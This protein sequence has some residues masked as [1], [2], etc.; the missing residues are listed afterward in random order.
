M[1][2]ALHTG[3]LLLGENN[4]SV[5]GGTGSAAVASLTWQSAVA[6]TGG[7]LSQGL[8]FLVIIYI[9]RRLSISEFGLISFA[10]AVSAYCLTLSNFG[11]PVFGSRAVARS[12][13]VP[14][15]LLGEIA[16]LRACLALTGMIVSVTVLWLAPEVSRLELLLI[17]IFGLSN[18]ALAGLFDWAFQGLHRQDVSAVLNIICQGGWLVLTVV[19][20]HL[21][22]GIMAVPTALSGAALI[23]GI[24]G[25]L[26]LR[27]TGQIR[28]GDN[29]Q[30]NVVRRSW[31]IL[32]LGA[33][34]GLGTLLVTVLIWSDAIVIR[35]L[36][37]QEAVGLY[38]A[39]NRAA[40][41]LAMLSSF[42]VQGAFPL[43]SRAGQGD[44]VHLNQYFQRCYEDMALVFVP[45]SIWAIFYAQSIILLVFRKPEYLA[46]TPV[47]RIF[48][49]TFLLAAL[50]NLFGIGVVVATHQDGEYQK[51]L[52]LAT[53]AFLPL[54]VGLSAWAGNLGASVAALVAQAV[55]L[56]LFL[57]KT[58]KIV[59]PKHGSALLVPILAGISVAIVSKL[60]GLNLYLS[61]GLLLMAYAFLLGNRF[62]LAYLS[63]GVS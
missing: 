13:Y 50:S 21:G 9:A 8:K 24:V 40:L 11:L 5:D 54:C 63:E 45:G 41:A 48:Q 38:A 30:L 61:A 43:L 59:Q 37:G 2:E 14:R 51:V 28:S 42:Y 33:P 56:L 32:K 26:W 1:P 35:L 29:D 31:E 7:I 49:V 19:G 57:R 16:C 4:I 55:S 22:M 46:A 60:I 3:K 52:V 39:G 44:R 62:R 20:M 18:V 27:Q 34:L 47:F 53:F 6:M 12:G 25:Y 15:G 17:G 58:R 36:R 10:I 23:A